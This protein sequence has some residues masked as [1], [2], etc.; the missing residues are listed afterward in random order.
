MNNSPENE[1][2][3]TSM[4]PFL[5]VYLGAMLRQL[6]EWTEQRLYV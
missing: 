4:K 5:Y 2:E 1:L 3:G 6:L